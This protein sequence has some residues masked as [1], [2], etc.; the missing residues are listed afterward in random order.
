[1][2][3]NLVFLI[4]IVYFILHGLLPALLAPYEKPPQSVG[5]AGM[6][7]GIFGVLILAS[8]W[9]IDYENKFLV[10]FILLLSFFWICVAVSLY[11]ASKIGRIACLILSVLRIPTLIGIPFSVFS[12][13]KLYFMQESKNFFDKKRK[14]KSVITQ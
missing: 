7:E 2:S 14:E 13:Y 9:F 1:M 8:L 3:I 10:K 11:K 12:I 6:I 5:V 4:I